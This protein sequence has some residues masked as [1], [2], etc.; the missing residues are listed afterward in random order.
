MTI[1][2][3][4]IVGHWRDVP[5]FYHGHNIRKVFELNKPIGYEEFFDVA[6]EAIFFMFSDGQPG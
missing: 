5:S 3:E 1:L 6:Y 2:L 4:S